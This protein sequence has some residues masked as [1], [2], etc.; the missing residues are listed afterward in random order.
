MTIE[1]RLTA[2]MKDAMRA[3]DKPRLETIRTARAALQSARLEAAKQRY[4]Q[5]ARAI[6]AEHAGDQTAREAALAAI[7]AD[8]H[9]ALDQAAQE[10]V[11]SKE[12]KRRRESAEMYRKGSRPELADKEEAEI[13]VL[14]TYLPKML[15]AAELRPEV[16]ALIGE[17]GLSG[18]QSMGKLMPTLL[19]RFKGRAESRTLSQL[20]KEL[21]AGS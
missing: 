18:P 13:A 17:L 9:A 5:A 10:A 1:E 19:E 3:G 11:I 12:I 4:D 15:S 8:G 2:D 7:S 21:L 20:A 14:E 16:A 6:E